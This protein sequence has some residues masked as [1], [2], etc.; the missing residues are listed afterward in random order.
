MTEDQCS[1]Q[2]DILTEA[3]KKIRVKDLYPRL[4]IALNAF[5]RLL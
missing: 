5:V 4:K 1:N 3:I 2:V